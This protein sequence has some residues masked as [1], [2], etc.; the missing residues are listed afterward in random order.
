M[1]RPRALSALLLSTLSC[2]AA[3]RSAPAPAPSSLAPAA[4]VASPPSPPAAARVAVGP[5][6]Q[7]PS[8]RLGREQVLAQ[9]PTGA[10]L[11]GAELR[12][13]HP[14]VFGPSEV[15]DPA[16]VQGFST[17]QGS[18]VTR[19]EAPQVALLRQHGFAYGAH[20]FPNFLTGYSHFYIADQPVYFS[21]DALLEPLHHSFDTLLTSLE[22]HAFRPALSQ[23]LAELRAQL[24]GPQGASLAPETRRDLDLYLSLTLALLEDREVTPVAGAAASELA[25]LRR[26]FT[27]AQGTARLRLFGAEREVDLSQFTPRG[28]YTAS[29]A[30]QRYF[31]AVMLLGREGLRLV[32]TQHG[33][34]VLHRPGV[35]AALGLHALLT[36]AAR[37]AL[38]SFTD[39]VA[40]VAGEPEA[41]LFSDL[42]RLAEGVRAAGGLARA[43]DAQLEALVEVQRGER[44]RVATA[45]LH[46]PDGIAGT[47]PEP[48][49]FSLSPQRYTPDAMVFSR[50]T[51][52]R[53]AA[54]AVRR[55]LPSSLDAA[56]GALGNEQALALLEPELAR[57]DYATELETSRALVDAHE[58]SW[59]SGSMYAVWLSALRTLSPRDALSDAGSLPRAMRTEPWGRRL[60]AAQ[61]ASWAE[62]RHDLVLYASQSYSM[63]PGCSYPAVYVDPYPALWDALGRWVE[64]GR[65]VV[66][67]ARWDSAQERARWERYLAHAGDVLQRLG[68]LARQERAGQEPSAEQLAWA[69]RA[70]NAHLQS[71]V[72]TSIEV[73]DAGW[74]FDLFE[75]R[76]QLGES[77]A[78]VADVHTAPAD[79][80]GRPVGNVLHVGTG[81]PRELVVLAGPP[82]RE[83]AYVGLG[84]TYLERVTTGFERLTDEQWRQSP[85]LARA[86]EWLSSLYA[87]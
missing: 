76:L 46:R 73:V 15:V 61:L 51:Y 12:G 24:G 56:Y 43:T 14:V 58:A 63:I 66:S 60:L 9:L 59:W 72:C 35:A 55:M 71:V 30:L 70:V 20:E 31:R 53:V 79:A 62:A 50:V 87:R 33:R 8:Q 7:A 29:P 40:A 25:E 49:Q 67:H 34:A 28:H 86:P 16:G 2:G 75:P 68:T 78:V 74:Y 83:R 69:N 44:P 48:V 26:V 32:D 42:D 82:G 39:G 84:F 21:A 18:A 10:R 47:V 45:L 52:D 23:A 38:E 41:L 5:G 64:R 4:S 85:T 81:A 37:S 27:A 65:S 80:D 13:R 19:L 57:F 1:R 11:S 22:E 77:R 6:Y 36:P 54:G 17:V 3:Q